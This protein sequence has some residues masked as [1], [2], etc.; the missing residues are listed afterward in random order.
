MQ[1]G[2]IIIVTFRLLIQ[3]FQLRVETVQEIGAVF[4]PSE[5]QALSYR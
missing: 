5:F 3:D 4:S 2:T 1:S